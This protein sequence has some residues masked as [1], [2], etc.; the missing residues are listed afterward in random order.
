MT[1]RVTWKAFERRVAKFLGGERTPLSGGNSKI[2]RADVFNAGDL[3]IEA[4]LRARPAIWTLYESTKEQ[5][6]AENK[7]PVLAIAKKN[8]K[9]FLICFHCD[10]WQEVTSHM[11][12]A[13]ES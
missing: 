13:N 7:I 11:R 5:A 12:G 2:T 3:F 6:R 9:G 10:N 8:S 4:K 1:A